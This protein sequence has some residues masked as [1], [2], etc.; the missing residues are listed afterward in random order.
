MKAI[1]TETIDKYLSGELRGQ[2]LKAFEEMLKTN[3]QL[4]EELKLE[5]DL[6]QII[7][8]EDTIGFRKEVIGVREEMKQQENRPKRFQK[9]FQLITGKWYLMAAS[10][11]ILVGIFAYL[12]FLQNRQI[13]NEKLFARYYSKYPSEI[14]ERSGDDVSNEPFVMGMN[15]YGK[16][17]F[18]GAIRYL[19]L[20]INADSSNNIARLYIGISYMETNKYDIAILNFK[21]I[22]SKPGN[23]FAGQAKWYLA[24]TYLKTN[25]ADYRKETKSLLRSIVQNKGYRAKEAQELLGKLK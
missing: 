23:M 12:Y 19:N 4:R 21:R 9:P 1:Y 7:L 17:N 14:A 18:E 16:N 24:L 2:E 5:R 8:D 20:T 10:V 25:N 6:D 13:S 22:I 15:E 3:Q 11:L